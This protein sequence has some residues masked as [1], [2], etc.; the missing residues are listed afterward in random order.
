MSHMNRSTPVMGSSSV[1]W[2][3]LEEFVRE[4]VQVVVQQLLEVEVSEFLGRQ[5][6]E[7]QDGVDTPSGYRNG[8]GKPRKLTLGSGTIEIRRPRVRD[9]EEQFVSRAL[10]LFRTR[11]REVNQLLPQLYL[12]GLALGDFDLAVKGL[13]GDDAPVSASVIARLKEKWLLEYEE[14]NQGALDHLEPVYLWADGIYVK[15]GLEKE[16][17]ALLVIIA[18]LRD[19]SKVVLSVT[20]GCRES[21][22]SWSEVLRDLWRAW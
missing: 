20:P 16:K 12:H 10:P 9:A 17:A 13:L 18:G 22:E 11:T 7:R 2:D 8:H 19:G 15:A 4:K 14:W 6:Y 1:C 3:E 5:R 21:V